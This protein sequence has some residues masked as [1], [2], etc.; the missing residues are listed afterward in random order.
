[1]L[2]FDSNTIPTSSAHL[3]SYINAMFYT[4]REVCV[5]TQRGKATE[6]NGEPEIYAAVHLLV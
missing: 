4:A 3:I 5:A 1:M 6:D 2:G